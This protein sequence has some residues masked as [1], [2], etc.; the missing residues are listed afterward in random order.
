MKFVCPKIIDREHETLI[1]IVRF[2]FRGGVGERER[3]RER[4][5]EGEGM[6]SKINR[7]IDR[8]VKRF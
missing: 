7:W 3:E 6:V 5:E 4:E 8:S 2:A 1:L